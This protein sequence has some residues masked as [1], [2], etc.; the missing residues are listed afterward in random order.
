MAV[1]KI[2]HKYC[3]Y[4]L[5]SFTHIKFC[6]TQN[7]GDKEK[8]RQKSKNTILKLCENRYMEEENDMQKI[9]HMLLKQG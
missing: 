6:F 4:N 8:N 5:V 9:L 3:C 7:F 1:Q 2:T